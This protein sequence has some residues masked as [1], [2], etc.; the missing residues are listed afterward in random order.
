MPK[1]AGEAAG[2]RFSV[3]RRIFTEKCI[4]G[5]IEKMGKR[6]GLYE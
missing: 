4:C 5:M 1:H 3:Y 6:S 2:G